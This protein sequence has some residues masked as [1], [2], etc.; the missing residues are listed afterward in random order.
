MAVRVWRGEPYPLGATWDGSGVNFAIFSE[1]ATAVDLCLFD[2]AGDEERVR[3]IERSEL[4][5]HCYLPDARPGQRYGYRVH[6]P[7]APHEGH[8]FNPAKLLIDP[9]AKRLDGAVRWDDALFGYRIGDEDGA[10]DER[11]SA[12]FVPKG[13][14]VDGSFSWGDDAPPRTAFE[15]TLIYEVHVGGFT[16][17]HPD[18]AEELRGTYAGMSSAPVVEHLVQL[19]VTAVELLPVHQHVDERHLVDRGLVNYWGYNTIGFFAPDVRYAATD[20][21]VGE[22]KSMVRRL[23]D[24]G[25]EVIL[26]VVYNHT[27]E[28]NHL[29]PTLSFRGIDNDDYYRLSPENRAALRRLHR[30]RQHP[31]RHRRLA[32]CG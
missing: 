21:P 12:S 5:W 30:H 11:D 26:D 13:V 32:S 31:R 8:R 9:Y 19:G 16:R 29:G 17:R 27:G 7:Y 14:V 24:A 1:H 22:F 23:H 6:G 20:D 10:A 28:S 4:I 15:S 2:D 3:L 18:V 25:I